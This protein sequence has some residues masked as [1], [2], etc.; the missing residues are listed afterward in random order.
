MRS[1]TRADIEIEDLMTSLTSL[2]LTPQTKGSTQQFILDWLDKLR[3]YEGMTPSAAHFPDIMKKAMLQNALNGLKV[4]RDV[5]TTEQLEV[6]KGN[7]PLSYQAYVALTQ[8]VAAGYD[9]TF[10]PATRRSPATSRQANVM[11]YDGVDWYEGDDNGDPEFDD[12]DEYFGSMSVSATQMQKKTAGNFRKRPSLPK[13]VWDV[14]SRAD[15]MAWDSISDQAKFKIIFAYKDHIA[16]K[17]NA[18]KDRRLAQAHDSTI[19]DEP[20]SNDSEAFQDAHQDQVEDFLD[21]ALL[22]QA[23][24]QKSSL[25]SQ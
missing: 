17:D 24:A 16:K 10:E 23:A 9:K 12:P 18:Q 11:E 21:S 1:S 15:Q 14:L 3:I 20:H 2:R 25:C 22:I 13:A 6:A 4:F 5:K 8:Q 7:G 19:S